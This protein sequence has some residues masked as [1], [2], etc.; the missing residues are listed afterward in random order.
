MSRKYNLI[1]FSKN[2]QQYKKIS[3]ILIGLGSIVLD[4]PNISEELADKSN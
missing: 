3:L 4:V 2:Y 1:L